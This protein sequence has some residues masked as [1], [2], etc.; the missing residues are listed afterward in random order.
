MCD[1]Q[2]HSPLY[3]VFAVATHNENVR[4]FTWFSFTSAR[5][6]IVGAILGVE[7]SIRRFE[8]L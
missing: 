3:K 1:D 8:E 5:T 2:H 4:F 6:H 7:Y